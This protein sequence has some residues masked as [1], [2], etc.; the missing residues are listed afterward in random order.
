MGA[1]VLMWGASSFF[2]GAT[3]TGLKSVEEARVKKTK[4]LRFPTLDPGTAAALEN[5]FVLGDIA[6]RLQQFSKY[7]ED[8]FQAFLESAGACSEF[9]L[10]CQEEELEAKFKRGRLQLLHEHVG[11]MQTQLRFLRRQIFQQNP[12]A[13]E[14][15]D[16]IAKEELGK[17]AKDEHHNFWCESY[18]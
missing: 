10:Q 6:E 16:S 11:A 3:K 2:S 8:V 9:L 13:L 14:D 17:Y 7:D 5:D 1:A 4:S 18:A 12:G 15:F